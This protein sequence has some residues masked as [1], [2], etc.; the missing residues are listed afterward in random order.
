MLATPVDVPPSGPGWV[1]ERKID[2]E[3]IL[4]RVDGGSVTLLTRNRRSAEGSYPEV[5][6]ELAGM[7]RLMLDGEVA[8]REG[9]FSALQQRMHVRAGPRLVARVPVVYLVFDLL[10]LD[11]YSTRDLPLTER[12]RLLAAAVSPTEV[13]GVH[14]LLDGD[15]PS[16]LREACRRG[17]EGIVAKR[18]DSPY[19][20]G[21]SR[22]W[23]K[24]KCVRRQELVVGGFTEP[25]GTRTGFGALL[26]G[27]WHDGEF[28][29]AGKVGS[30]F[31]E[32]T[33]RVLEEFL[34]S[35]ERHDPPFIDPPSGRGIHWVEPVLVCEVGFSDWTSEGRLRQPVFVG[36]LRDRDPR[37]VTRESPQPGSADLS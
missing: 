2:G 22:H 29:Y 5:A 28:R 11:G 14:P 25:Q 7:G 23:S 21:R 33:L 9:G 10:H 20:S 1:F 27:Y 36:L 30:G 35:I 13:V 31:D 16:L 4:A 3:R 15:G 26:V 8:A 12:R 18:A 37:R 19:R 24:S 34:R 17:W 6:E 32:A